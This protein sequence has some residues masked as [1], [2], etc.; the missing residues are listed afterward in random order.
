MTTQKY[1][2]ATVQLLQQA[3]IELAAGDTRQAAEK[4]W[5]AAAQKVKAICEERGWRHVSHRDLRNAAKALSREANYREIRL[6]FDAVNKLHK[7]FYED[8]YNAEEVGEG[9]DDVRR[10][11]DKLDALSLAKGNR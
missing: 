3:E 10:F 1:Q 9:L 2:D 5:G 7:N 4:G 8:F 6:L 11:V